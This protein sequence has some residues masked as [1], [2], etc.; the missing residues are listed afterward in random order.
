MA[1]GEL[2]KHCGQQETDHDERYMP[3]FP[4]YRR[5]KRCYSCSLA[6]CVG[7]ESEEEPEEMT[8]FLEEVYDRQAQ[9]R[10][11]WGS[12]GATVR[13]QNFDQRI[14]DLNLEIRLAGRGLERESLERARD[15]LMESARSSH[16]LYIG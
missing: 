6:N 10:F 8:P 1:N 3:D 15:E 14:H 2:C 9:R 12:Y 13:Q 16:G 5:K 7:F 4:G 11:A